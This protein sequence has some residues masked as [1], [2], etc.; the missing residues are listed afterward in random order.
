MVLVKIWKM[1]GVGYVEEGF[2]REDTVREN[3][4]EKEEIPLMVK[5]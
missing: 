3:G 4:E 1:I 5:I 2:L